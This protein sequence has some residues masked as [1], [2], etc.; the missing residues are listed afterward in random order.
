[1][2]ASTLHLRSTA[3]PRPRLRVDPLAVALLVAVVAGLAA[4]WIALAAGPSARVPSAAARVALVV[5]A[6]ERPAHA[7][8]AARAA[9]RG[10]DDVTIRV[11]RTASEAAADV[12]YFAA[13]RYGRVIAVGPVARAA[14]RSVTGDYPRTR[15]VLR[16]R[17]P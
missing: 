16:A 5:D 13:Q 2:T 9:A 8:A 14:A 3:R 17:V 6:G 7:L 4:L 11:P 10:R 12:R 1:M 15:F